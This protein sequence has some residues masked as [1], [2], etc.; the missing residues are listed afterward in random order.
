MEFIYLVG[1]EN[2]ISYDYFMIF[3]EKEA[4]YKYA[5]NLEIVIFK[6][7]IKNI[8][9]KLKEKISPIINIFSKIIVEKNTLTYEEKFL[10]YQKLYREVFSLL[11]K[12]DNLVVRELPLH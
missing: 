8:K 11:P 3:Q 5:V 9:P 6:N 7:V 2:L 12:F 10:H 1:L 4:A